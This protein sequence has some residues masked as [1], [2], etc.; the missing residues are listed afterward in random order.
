LHAVSA[1]FDG[2][3]NEEVEPSLESTA[4]GYDEAVESGVPFTAESE[5][6]AWESA[7]PV[8]LT[9]AEEIPD[10]EVF[11]QEPG[12][13]LRPDT[14]TPSPDVTSSAVEAFEAIEEVA[15]EVM[16]EDEEIASEATTNEAETPAPAV[17]EDAASGGSGDDEKQ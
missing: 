6:L 11:L 1:E 8:P 9:E 13:D 15:A 3:M 14:I 2:S 17:S 7:D 5:I 12:R 16:A 10:D 4:A